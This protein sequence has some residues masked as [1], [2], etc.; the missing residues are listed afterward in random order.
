MTVPPSPMK[1]CRHPS[2]QPSMPPSF[3]AAGA[4]ASDEASVDA[5]VDP[6]VIFFH[7]APPRIWHTWQESNP[8][9]LSLGGFGDR[10]SPGERHV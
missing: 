9:R 8:L 5:A 2:M 7:A 6:T 4:A 3:D 10:C 1:S